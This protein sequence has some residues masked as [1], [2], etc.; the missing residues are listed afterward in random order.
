MSFIV[1]LLAASVGSYVVWQRNRLTLHE[2][3]HNGFLQIMH[4]RTFHIIDPSDAKLASLSILIKWPVSIAT[5]VK[6]EK[7][8]SQH[9]F[10]LFSQY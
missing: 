9:I 4:T 10:N 3:T 6:I 7:N 2:S 8:I 1:V 5:I